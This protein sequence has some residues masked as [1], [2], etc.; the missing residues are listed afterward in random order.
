MDM[1]QYNDGIRSATD[2]VVNDGPK[3]PDGEYLVA[4]TEHEEKK[5][6]AYT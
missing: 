1:T 6:R 4:I 5:Q 3:Y 2:E